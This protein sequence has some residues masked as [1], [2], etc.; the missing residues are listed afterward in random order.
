MLSAIQKYEMILT[1]NSLMT[2]KFCLFE[3]LNLRKRFSDIA[4]HMHMKK[5]RLYNKSKKSKKPSHKKAFKD[6][7]SLIRNKL[8]LPKQHVRP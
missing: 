3:M 7:R 5:Q 4:T 2:G 6:I 1:S 8:G